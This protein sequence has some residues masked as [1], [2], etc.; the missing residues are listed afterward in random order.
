[1]SLLKVY[2]G[3]ALQ[4][5]LAEVTRPVTV[6]YLAL[7]Q[8]E[9]DTLQALADLIQLT[10]HLSVTTRQE[11]SA[12]ADRVIVQGQQGMGLIFEGAPLGTE[13]A[14]LISAIVVAGR[15]DSGLQT[16]TRQLLAGLTRPVHLE[17]FT[18]PT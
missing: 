8:P 13:L 1:M 14:A 5:A 6:T 2:Q 15:G 17:V 12:A 3:R 4:A 16:K 7:D 11:T 10:P 9:S 18:T